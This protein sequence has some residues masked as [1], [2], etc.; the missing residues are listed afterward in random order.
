MGRGKVKCF[1]PKVLIFMLMQAIE[2]DMISLNK[3]GQKT[4]ILQLRTS[5]VLNNLEIKTVLG[6]FDL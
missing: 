6:L 3:T 4:R 1:W 2:Q 5:R